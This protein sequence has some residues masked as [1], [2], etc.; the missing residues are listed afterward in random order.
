MSVQQSEHSIA[1][2]QTII[3]T[4]IT[5]IGAA[6]IMLGLALIIFAQ[7]HERAYV[8]LGLGASGFIG[9]IAG[10]IV[11]GH[12]T[13]AALGYGVIAPGIVGILVGLNYL[14]G[15]YGPGPNLAHGNL[16]ISLS[17]IVLLTG[18]VGALIVQPK[19]GIAAI[20][21]V[22]ML[23]VIG[24]IGIAAL[25]AGTIYLVVLHYPGYAYL[26][27][28]IGAVCLTGGIVC[29]IFAQRRVKANSSSLTA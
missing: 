9:G 27:L 24:S 10:I 12:K 23:G 6:A 11:V 2:K 20:L 13:R 15:S 7:Y 21:S 25:I 8:F 1:Q 19:A 5:V 4:I 16:V 26:L 18:M 22:F 28:A 17:S 14:T 3:F 29:G